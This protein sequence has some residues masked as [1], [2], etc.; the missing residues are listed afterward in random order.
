MLFTEFIGA[1]FKALCNNRPRLKFGR[2][3][4]ITKEGRFVWSGEISLPHLVFPGDKL[5]LDAGDHIL[6]LVELVTVDESTNTGMFE[7]GMKI[8]SKSR[9]RNWLSR[10]FG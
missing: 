4:T 1:F 5:S 7:N 3:I 2:E 9:K 8:S 10:L 6:D